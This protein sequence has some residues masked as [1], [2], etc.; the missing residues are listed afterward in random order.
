SH[1]F[2][3]RTDYYHTLL[4]FAR[5]SPQQDFLQAR[6]AH[7]FPDVAFARS[8]E[9]PK[10]RYD[11]KRVPKKVMEQ[12]DAAN[13]QYTEEAVMFRPIIKHGLLLSHGKA[14]RIRGRNLAAVVNGAGAGKEHDLPARLPAPMAPIDIIAVHEQ[15]FVQK[16]H[17]IEGF[18]AH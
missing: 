11:S 14:N 9:A 15:T 13:S 17:P 18:A 8:S 5:D 6:R 16:P 4:G 10:T 7:L 12:D 2:I 3:T 1:V